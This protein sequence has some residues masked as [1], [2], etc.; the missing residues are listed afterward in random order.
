MMHMCVCVVVVVVVVGASGVI[1]PLLV[2]PVE[3]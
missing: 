1:I 2:E 3:A